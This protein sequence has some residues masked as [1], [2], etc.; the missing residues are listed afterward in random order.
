MADAQACAEEWAPLRR[1]GQRTSTTKKALFGRL[2]RRKV[3]PI[4][5]S[6]KGARRFLVIVGVATLVACTLFFATRT[7]RVKLPPFDNKPKR[8]LLSICP[9]GLT[10]RLP[11][12]VL[13]E[14]AGISQ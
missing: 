6:R 7:V 9:R 5:R 1:N 13:I 10:Q 4:I 2:Y 12:R 14:A 3:A 8:K 11:E